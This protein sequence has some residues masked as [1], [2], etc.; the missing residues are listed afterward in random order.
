LDE[1][2]EKLT[3]GTPDAEN[4]KD[5]M[6]E[7]A[8]VFKEEL[9]KAKQEAEEQNE[10]LQNLQVEG[11]NPQTV[12][13]GK[14]MTIS[15][16]ELCEYC[17]ERRRG[18][19]KNPDSPYCSECEETLEKYPYDYRGI[20]AVIVT[21]CIA[22]AAVFCFALSVPL[23]ATMKQ[24]D[25][26]ADEGKLY[27]AI[28]KYNDAAEYADI[29]SSENKCYNLHRKMAIVCFD[30]VNMNSAINEIGDNIPDTI[31]NLLTFK[32]V[33]DILE[34]SE[35]MQATAMVAQQYIGQYAEVNDETYEKI[36]GHLDALSGKKI[37]ISETEYHDET[38][39]DF[40]PDGT[41]TVV[42]ADE[43]WLCMYKYA[44]A[45]QMEK[46]PEIIAG[47]L[48]D[49]ADSSEYMKTL[50]GS[51]L[52][53]TYAGLLEDYDKAE[54]L[55]NDLKAANSE[56]PEYHM[57]MSVVY[58]HR[59]KDYDKALE[60]CEEGLQMLEALPNG[61]NY[62]M[63]YGY[64]LHIQQTLNFIMQDKYD[65]AYEVIKMAYD[66]LSMTGGLTIQVRDLYAMLAL[67]TKD[68]DT[69]DAL[70]LE[71]ESYGDESITFTSDVTDYQSGKLTLK[72][73]AESG[74][75]DLI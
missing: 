24:A 14:R 2:K 21:V 64:M 36:I 35:R 31:L 62:M 23:F 52:A 43:G 9:A 22:V 29:F 60:L 17:G 11:Y 10:G 57:V 54:E 42:I 34:A 28:N 1:N 56:S 20:I 69:F 41:E 66:N 70:A 15:D 13:L 59:D 39:K 37:Y 63:Q 46:D 5:E 65:E 47:Y 68:Q 74:R 72:E 51:L 4:I 3:G 61:E 19:E 75:Y 48:Q 7:L 25:K 18:T 73:I 45:Q 50:V 55:A 32:D 67:E 58:R 26:A 38:E 49:V 44:A 16:D 30:M 71:I 6:E 12:S 40:T 53:T 27:T 8:K 33:N